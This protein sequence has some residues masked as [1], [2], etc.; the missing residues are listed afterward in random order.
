MKYYINID[1]A[2]FECTK[3]QYN[4]LR[5]QIGNKELCEKTLDKVVNKRKIK[6][7]IKVSDCACY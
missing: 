4:I 6:R 3:R 2:L 5:G 1:E 7:N